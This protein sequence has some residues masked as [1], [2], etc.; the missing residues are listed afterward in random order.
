MA[1]LYENSEYFRAIVNPG[2]SE[3]DDPA[4]YLLSADQD[5]Y[6]MIFKQGIGNKVK[7]GYQVKIPVARSEFITGPDDNANTVTIEKFVI[8]FNE[9][10]YYKNLKYITCNYQLIKSQT[11]GDENIVEI[12]TITKVESE[13]FDINSLTLTDRLLRLT[14]VQLRPIE[15]SSLL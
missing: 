1:D 15:R 9:N 6:A 7:D 3:D 13:A 12:P 8:P 10:Y 4:T 11:P 5:T 14:P 2:N